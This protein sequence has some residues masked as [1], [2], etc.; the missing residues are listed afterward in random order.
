[1]KEKITVVN[2]G[3]KR[4]EVSVIVVVYN[5]PREAP[6]SLLSLSARYQRHISPDD[7]EV[8]VVDNGSN[9][10]FDE[11][12]LKG[13]E[14]NFRLIRLD[15]A[16]PSPAHAIN[17]GLAEAQGDV[18]GVMIDGA[19]I[20]TPG[21]VHFA[22]HGARLYKKSVVATLGWYLGYDFQRWSMQVGYD[23]KTEDALLSK[24][25]WPQDGYRLF[26]IGTLDESSV[27]GW[28]QSLS[29]SN[30]L[31]LRRET[32]NELGGVEERFD[33]P[34]GGYLNLDTFK[35]AVELPGAE[36][37][38]LLGEGTFHQL[39]GGVATNIPIEEMLERNKIWHPQYYSI[40]GQGFLLPQTKTPPT[41]LGLLPAAALAYFAR[42]AIDPVFSWW[43][44]MET[45]LG[46][47]FDRD[48]WSLTPIK[49]PS[50]PTIATLVDLAH[51][52]FRAGRHAAAAALARLIRKLAPDEPEPQR[53]LSLVS[54]AQRRGD[55]PPDDAG[56]HLTLSR[57]YRI[58]GD[59]ARAKV[60]HD[61]AIEVQR[62][63]ELAPSIMRR[64]LR[65]ARSPKRTLSILVRLCFNAYSS[66]IRRLR[67]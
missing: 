67:N 62:R 53:L 32:W 8:I 49:R 5:I 21:L 50:D 25:E 27:D 24:I 9:P 7:Y 47:S 55:P 48:L 51:D 58:L 34:G 46:A 13:L 39:H 54:G 26:E 2:R 41:Y 18:I 57:A 63:S 16:P 66:L 37:V 35:R 4:P 45:P 6:R 29:E 59:K 19:R 30:A 11:S 36:L 22:L 33:E 42:A 65:A 38:I 14:G 64:A 23:A 10:P 40:R 31:F 17:R 20:V 44:K 12:V 56:Y 52:E 15:P 43:R 1:M 28:F 3:R 60:E 61:L